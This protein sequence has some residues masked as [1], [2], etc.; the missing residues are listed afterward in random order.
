[1]TLAKVGTVR[2]QPGYFEAGG[3]FATPGAAPSGTTTAPTDS[4]QLV[5]AVSRVENAVRALPSRQ[6]ILWGQED[7]MQVE[8]GLKELAKDRRQGAI[9]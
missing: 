1:M 7:T 8:Q 3:T 4:Q 5:Q 6:H 9:N 2:R